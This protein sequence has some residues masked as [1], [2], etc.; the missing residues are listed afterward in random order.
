ML[1]NYMFW[2][3]VHL[4]T[5]GIE[6]ITFYILFNTVSE[7]KTSKKVNRISFIVII[8][9][10][11][12]FNMIELKTNIRI[13][14]C[15]VSSYAFY[16]INYNVSFIKSII[17]PL[18]FITILGGVEILSTGIV[19]VI[20]SISISE[21]LLYSVYRLEAIILSKSIAFICILYFSYFRLSGELSKKEYIYISI[22]VFSNILILLTI[23]TYAIDYIPSKK[24]SN[25]IIIF[26]SSLLMLSS[27]FLIIIIYK[28]LRNNKM[29]LEH[30]LIKERINMECNYYMNVENNQEKIKRLYHD[31]KN[32][33]ICIANLDDI[34]KVHEYVKNINLEIN[35][36]DNHFNTGNKIVD[37][38]MS[39]KKCLCIKKGISLNSFLDFSKLNFIDMTDLCIILSNALDNA[40]Q[41][42]EKIKNDKT[43]KYI[44]IKVTYVK[45]FCV[46]NIENSKVN[47]V[48]RVNGRIVS[49]KKNKFIKGIGIKN[50]KDVVRKYDGEVNINFDKNK[51][52]LTIMI[53]L[54]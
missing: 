15:L 11:F 35:S 10:F 37:I 46:I 52:L 13:L 4:F 43:P 21:V 40:I 16:K 31:M 22:P 7:K 50:I 14:I 3:L 42:C 29:R 47:K 54:K 20:N 27:I 45:N 48:L 51:F 12:A 19:A 18:I 6:L 36:M 24:A 1:E 2:D 32:H 38:I 39:D 25:Y 17:I 8:F 41:A 26:I 5:L 9:I 53:P 44:N 28:I 23:Y 33:M 30:K 34:E 49:D